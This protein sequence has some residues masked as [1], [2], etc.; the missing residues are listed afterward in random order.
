MTLVGVLSRRRQAVVES[1]SV[2]E[3]K[4]LLG[5]Y[6]LMGNA[7]A[8]GELE[9]SQSNLLTI[10]GLPEPVVKVKATRL[11]IGEEIREFAVQRK[12]RAA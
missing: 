12:R 11:W 5:R 9:V 2:E 8:A 4:W 10:S 7:E 1:V 3:L 6:G